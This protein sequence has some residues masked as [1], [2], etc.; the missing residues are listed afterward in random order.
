MVSN[1]TD[2]GSQKISNAVVVWLLRLISGNIKLAEP[3]LCAA[4]PF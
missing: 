1:S 3:G 2:S 4:F